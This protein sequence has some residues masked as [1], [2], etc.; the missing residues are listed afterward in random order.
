M[1]QADD[2]QVVTSSPGEISL[3]MAQLEAAAV[4]LS[5]RSRMGVLVRLGLVNQ[6][7]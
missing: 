6:A 5:W 7:G 1:D 4:S 3:G 2:A